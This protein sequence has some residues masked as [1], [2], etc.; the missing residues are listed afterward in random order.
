MR[1]SAPSSS[2]RSYSLLPLPPT[3]NQNKVQAQCPATEHLN[4]APSSHSPWLVPPT[5]R[6]SLAPPQPT[7][8][9][10][11]HGT[12]TFPTLWYRIHVLL[13]DRLVGEYGLYPEGENW[14]GLKKRTFGSRKKRK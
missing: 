2:P 8:S 6:K 11:K 4:L 3:E 9:D 13:H 5:A 14:V 10:L 7:L 1:S 12:T